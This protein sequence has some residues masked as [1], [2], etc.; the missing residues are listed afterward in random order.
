[1]NL[2][3]K[4]KYLKNTLSLNQCSSKTKVSMNSTAPRY[5]LSLN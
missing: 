4:K 3:I 1:M 2:F 5:S